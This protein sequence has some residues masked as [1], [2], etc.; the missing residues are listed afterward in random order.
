MTVD[1]A[2]LLPLF[3]PWLARA[4]GPRRKGSL[5]CMTRRLSQHSITL[6][7]SWVLVKAMT[8][9]LHP[10][11][12]HSSPNSVYETASRNR[13]SSR[14]KPTTVSCRLVDKSD[15]RLLISMREACGKSRAALTP[16][17]LFLTVSL[18]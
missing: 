2:A 14:T 18:V 10:N 12:L 7:S 11:S 15:E 5:A 9:M 6:T 4:D 1:S 13:P 16:I 8:Q 17:S 3:L